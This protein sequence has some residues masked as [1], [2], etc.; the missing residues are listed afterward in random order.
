MTTVTPTE[1][2]SYRAAAR[3]DLPGIEGLLRESS[4]PTVGVAEALEQFIVA[5]RGRRLVGVVGL[6]LHG[7]R[8][9]LLRSAAVDASVRG[10][11]VGRQLVEQII[12]AARARNLESLYLLTTTAE[13]YFP[14]FGFEEITRDAVPDVVK[15]SA[16]FT[17][18]CPA[19][20]VVMSLHLGSSA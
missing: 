3:A 1:D 13:R 9:A 6:E 14:M 7:D 16:E 19:S 15:R 11:G 8:Y 4:L 10:R 5:E 2:I 18:A 17:S 12:G 20:A